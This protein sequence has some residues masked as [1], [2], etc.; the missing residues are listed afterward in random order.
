VLVRPQLRGYEI[1]YL[2]RSGAPAEH[3]IALDDLTVS[4]K[5]NRVVLRSRR[6][7]REVRPFLTTA[8]NHSEA[9]NLGVYRF[10]CAVGLQ[11]TRAGNFH[12]GALAGAPYLPRVRYGR[13]VLSLAR[14]NL[15]AD[16]LAP[17]RRGQAAARHQRLAELRHRRN[18][19]RWIAYVDHD[20]VLPIDLD[21]VLA[22]DSFL[23]LPKEKEQAIVT[24]L[25]EPERLCVTGPEGR[26]V[27]QFILP[28]VH[29]GEHEGA[30]AAQARV[31]LAPPQRRKSAAR[32][33][34]AKTAPVRRTCLPGGEWLYA[35]LYTGPLLAD[36]LLRETLAPVIAG[37]LRSGAADAWFFLRYVDPGFHL[38]LRF[39]G[40]PVRLRTEVEPALAAAA[41]G[42]L[43]ARQIW[44]YQIDSY[45][46]EIERYGGDAGIA[47]SE[48]VFHA[49]SQA[50]LDLVQAIPRDPG[51][52]LRWRLTLLGMDRLLEDFGFDLPARHALVNKCRAGFAAEHGLDASGERGLGARFRQERAGLESLLAG[53]G[54]EALAAGAGVF[55]AR[56]RTG[57]RVGRRL[58]TLA[59]NN[60]LTRSL[61]D[62]AA[63]HL[64]MHANRM[65]PSAARL[66]ELVLYD[67][68]G[69]LYLGALA[70][71]GQRARAEPSPKK[72][73]AALAG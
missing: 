3:Q 48:E 33:A 18:L 20:H 59:E 10:L 69:R 16:E 66:H 35:K 52:E 11:D 14:W 62:I 38:R 29:E 41:E 12:W 72:K 56:S 71:A 61:E 73:P 25:F 34:L 17:L 6:L 15:N 60:Q 37:A 47:L 42:A 8:H 49:D 26:F 63:S 31:A 55:T 2:G 30:A 24:E 23:Q 53:Q 39:H 40:D 50:T 19:P 67:F 9:A 68:L 13:V 65:L 64:H 4:V 1:P 54:G 32:R 28:F 36:R 70:R 7:G 45:E 46:R 22:V 57:R 5:G 44:K 21:N 27:H 51:A 58:R 43:G